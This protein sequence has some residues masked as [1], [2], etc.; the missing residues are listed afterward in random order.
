[1]LAV[2]DDGPGVEPAQLGEIFRPGHRGPNAVGAGSGLGL[3]I[4]RRLA[5]TFDADL[6]ARNRPGGGFEAVLTLPAAA[7][8]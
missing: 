5:Q 6:Q 8:A 1:V 2:L 3:S 7:R 4:A